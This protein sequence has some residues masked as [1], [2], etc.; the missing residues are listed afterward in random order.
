MPILER[1][2][3]LKLNTTSME[4]VDFIFFFFSYINMALLPNFFLI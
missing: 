4:S 3:L 2:E 1:H